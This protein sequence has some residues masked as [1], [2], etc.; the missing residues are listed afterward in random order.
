MEH[1]A[2]W[3]ELDIKPGLLPAFLAAA[4]RNAE[5]AVRDEPGC[6]R[7]DILRDPALA[8]RVC[9]YEI[10]TDESAFDAHR[11]TAH[12]RTYLA[13]T[14]PMI[15]ARKSTRLIVAPHDKSQL[16]QDQGEQT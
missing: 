5:G 1:F 2:L 15:A 16:R 3:V 9:L 4:R 10:Y 6:H 14:P 12:F 11:K 8:N 13:T 7:F